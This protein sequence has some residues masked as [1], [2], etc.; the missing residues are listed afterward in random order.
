MIRE[1]IS[2]SYNGVKRDVYFAMKKLKKSSL[3]VLLF[4]L[5]LI[6]MI[7]LIVGKEDQGTTNAINKQ[8]A[9]VISYPV[10]IPQLPIKPR[11]DAKLLF[12]GDTALLEPLGSR[13]VNDS[14][15][16]PLYRVMAKFQEY[17][18][19]VGKLEA[20]IDGASVGEPNPGKGYTFSIPKESVRVFKEAG[21][22]AFSYATNHT[23]DYGPLS[24]THTIQLLKEASIDSF[25]AGANQTEAF[26]PLVKEI[27]GTKIAFLAFNSAEYAFNI[28]D[29][30]TPGTA[31]FCEWLVRQSIQDAKTQADLV[32]VYSEAGD[33]HVSEPND[34][35]IQWANI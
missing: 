32:I 31:C 15:Y 10:S 1:L 28:A 5:F 33:E 30:Y 26:T 25:G 22:D 24:V 3:F 7:F 27:N 13:V 21:I 9:Q 35:Q 6:T 2:K 23:R 20:T 11:T 4:S 14:S 18:Y 19:V 17:D 8:E 16:N 29:Q 12:F 34:L